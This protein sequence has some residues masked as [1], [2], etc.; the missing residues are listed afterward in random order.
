MPTAKSLSD[1]FPQKPTGEP[2]LYAWSSDEIAERWRGC[3]K[4]GQTTRDVNE[5]IRE[6]QGQARVNYVLQVDE[7]ALDADGVRITDSA[8]RERL[9]AKGFENVVY[10]SSKEWIRCTRADVLTAITELREHTELSGSHH[11]TFGMR[12]EQ[13]AAVE[14]TLRF[15][16]REWA[17]DG[18]AVPRFLWNAKMRFG[19]TFTSYQ[20]AKRMGAKRV[21]VVTFKPAVADAW[22]TD[23]NSHVDFDGWIYASKDSGPDN[24]LNV[25][26]EKALVYFGSFQDLLGREK[27]TG[28][29]KARNEWIHLINWDLV[30]FDEYHFGAWRENAKELFE[31]RTSKSRKPR[32][33]R[34]SVKIWRF[35]TRSW[36]S[37]GMT[38]R[39]SC[40][41]PRRRS[42][43]FRGRRSVRWPMA[44]LL[45]TT[46]ITGPIPTNSGKKSTGP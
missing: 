31:G 43:T 26:H 42:Y 7:P 1:L 19:K 36:T 4:V 18:A 29:I 40:R 13:R 28:L 6:S 39:I 3:L 32:W 11:E 14:K 34:N 44:S 22:E 12:D 10:E 33:R 37:S 24:P 21:L 27:G 45:T 5:R 23:L 8:V 46:F 35:W 25:D 20:L 2:R 16:Q 38:R 15:F 30:I 41:L 9:I 17:A